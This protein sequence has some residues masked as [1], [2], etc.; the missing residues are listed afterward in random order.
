MKRNVITIN[1]N[2]GTIALG[3]SK[4]GYD[5][6]AIYINFSDK[7]SYTVCG[8][9][10]GAIVRDNN[11]DDVCDNDE[12]DL[13]NIDCLAGRLRISSISRAGCKDRSIICQNERELRAIIDILE[14]IHPRC[15]LL[16]CANR[17]QGNNIISD[18][19]EEIKHM[20][21]TVDIK[22][23]NTRNITG[24]PVKEKGSFIIGALN[25]NDINLEFLD[26]IDSR[27]YLIDEFLEAK[28]D[29][30]WYYNIKQ[31]L[32]YRSEIDNR[33]GVLCWNKDRYKYEKN[34]FWNPRMIPLI[35]QTGSVRKIT[36]REIARLK[37][38]P[39]EYLLNIRNK[40]NLYQQLMFIPNVFLIQQI[41]FSLCLSDREEDYLSRM[42]LKSKRF[43]E[44]L[45]AYF[46]HKNM[47]NSL[48][49]A[50]EDS[51]I[52]F[53]YVTDSATYCFVFKIYNNNSGIENRILA[54]SKKI[55]ENENL[56]ETIPI[57]V[58][59]NVVGNESKKYVEKEFGFFVWDV[60]N[61]L[62]MLQECPK[63]RSEFVSMLSFNVTDITPQKI[64]QKLFVQK[65]E[66]LVKWDLQERLRTIKP[67]QADAREYEQLCVDILK[68]LFSE[69]V[70][71]FDEQKKSN[72]RLY[73]FDFCG[74]IRTINTSEFFDTVQ[75]F[76]GTKYLI[77][78]F[79]NYEKAISQKEIYTTEKYLYE[80]ALRKVAIIISRK[81]MDENAQKA[82][83]GSLRELGKLIIGLSDEDVN[84]LI[85]MKDNDEDPSDYLQV[86]LD[87]MLIDLEK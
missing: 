54:I 66:S 53:R 75:K 1:D 9:N 47:E 39:D 21:Y 63:L 57:L 17:I 22:S 10:W 2:L 6:R 69:N 7:I 31:D 40:S 58:I 70:E 77:F 55:Y 60:E 33:D 85:D 3:F 41:A 14:G 32:L 51:M 13:S 83:R 48:Y 72:N 71:F 81:G 73:R 4:A 16:Q 65:K 8:D 42:V 79:K 36:H 49:N 24:F 45:F 25:H 26:N 30:K 80:K 29:D 68:Y 82:S 28:S 74:K 52:D 5:V 84:K 11:W 37:G 44:I 23:F 64:E 35:V 61:I 56:S 12:L 62:W 86:L 87:N 43:K 67:G 27:D 76:F 34:I 15:F 19:C 18:L 50:E 78:E 38:I 46:A 59:G 20:G